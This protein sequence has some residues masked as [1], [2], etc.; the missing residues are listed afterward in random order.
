MKRPVLVDD[1]QHSIYQ[2][3]SLEVGELPKLGCASKM[4]RVER[5]TARAAQRT[6]FGDFDG[7]G[8]SGTGKDAG[9]CV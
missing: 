2:L 8:G 9:P 5:I 3:V 4:G 1:G 6:F 7:K